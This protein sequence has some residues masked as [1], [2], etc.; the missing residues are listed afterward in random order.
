MW[1]RGY[2]VYSP[3]RSLVLHEYH[4]QNRKPWK[5]NKIEFDASA[6]R[7]KTIMGLPDGDQSTKAVLGSKLDEMGWLDDNEIVR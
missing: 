2:D 4:R 7:L 5:T 3:H 1:T 6:N